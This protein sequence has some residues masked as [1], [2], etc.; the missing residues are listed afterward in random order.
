MQDYQKRLALNLLA[1]AVQRNLSAERLCALSGIEQGTLVKATGPAL[2][3]RQATDLWLNAVHLSHD[4]LFGLHF[5]ESVQVA[6]LGVVGE[7]IRSS[8]TIGEALTHAAGFAHLITDLFAMQVTR[9][10]QTFAIRY[11]A[12]SNH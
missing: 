1:Y 9:S 2:T 8:R 11:I 6:A 3:A 10:D 5:G 4:P 7:L 12:N